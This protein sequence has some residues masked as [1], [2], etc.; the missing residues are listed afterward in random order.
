MFSQTSHWQIWNRNLRLNRKSF[1][2]VHRQIQVVIVPL[3]EASPIDTN[4]K[5]VTDRPPLNNS[6]KVTPRP[7]LYNQVLLIR[8]VPQLYAWCNSRIR[9]H[10]STFTRFLIIKAEPSSIVLSSRLS[11]DL[12]MTRAASAR[13][14]G[15]ASFFATYR[16]MLQAEVF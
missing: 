14:A 1:S 4:I 11:L 16:R 12:L 8:P 5:V 9:G 13:R 10:L 6:M 2:L 3:I 15:S 7:A